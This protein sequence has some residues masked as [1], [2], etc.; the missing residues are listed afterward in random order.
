MGSSAS[1]DRT[2]PAGSTA[3]E[4]ILRAEIPSVP[5]LTLDQAVIEATNPFY[6]G[7]SFRCYFRA[8]GSAVLEYGCYG[9]PYAISGEPKELLHEMM[10]GRPN[11][12]AMPVAIHPVTKNVLMSQEHQCQRC[13][14]PLFEPAPAAVSQDQ[15][16]T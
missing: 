1:E 16:D 7:C 10:K 13:H 8:D 14:Y 2:S 4:R 12:G 9:G 11:R 5:A 6:N 15:Q 3:G